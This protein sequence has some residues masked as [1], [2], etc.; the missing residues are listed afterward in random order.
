VDNYGEGG[1]GGG[2]Y[3]VSSNAVMFEG[4]NIAVKSNKAHLLSASELSW[5]QGLGV[6]L[7]S[8]TSTI[9]NGFDY[10]TQVT[11]NTKI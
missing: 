1:Y 6:Y 11:G 9:T 4:T 2:I 7:D 10:T 5:Y 8:G 3:S